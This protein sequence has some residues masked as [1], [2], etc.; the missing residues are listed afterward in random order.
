MYLRKLTISGFKSFADKVEVEFDQGVTGIIGPNGCGKS[1]VSDSIRWVL[2]EQNARRLRGT[3]MLDMIFN[4]TASRPAE[5][6]AEVSLLF[7]NSDGLLPVSY[8][9]VLITRRLFRNGESEYSINK[10][11]CRMK[12]VTDLFLDSGIGTSS[13]SLMEQGRVDMIVNAKP[14]ERRLILEE[15][16]GVSRFLHRKNDALRKLERTEGD[17]TRLNDILSELQRQR[18]S[19]ERQAR[20]ASLARKYRTDLMEVEYILHVRSGSK[21]Q[22]NLEEL[23]SKIKGLVAR[24]EA[25]EGEIKEVRERKRAL[26][27]NLEQQDDLNRKQRDTWASSNARLEQMENQLKSLTERLSEYNQLKVRLLQECEQD[28]QRCEEE[29]ERLLTTEQLIE[30][31]GTETEL[32]QKSIQTLTDEQTRISREFAE[33]ETESE[34][35]RKV[36]L[37]LEQEIT[38]FKNHQRLWDRDKEFYSSRLGKLNQEREQIRKELDTH[39]SRKEELQKEGEALDLLVVEMRRQL[40][41]VSQLVKEL[42]RTETETRSAYQQCERQWQQAH[43]RWESLTQLQANLAGFDE[44]VRFLLRGDQN[45]RMPQLLCTLAEKIQVEKG[46]EMA[47]DTALSRKLQ[48]IVAENDQVV[49]DAVRKLRDQKK[50]RV[51]FLPISGSIGGSDSVVVPEQ[52]RSLKAAGSVV[53]CDESLLP[54][55]SRMLENVYIAGTLEEALQLRSVLP[56]GCRIVTVEGDMVDSDGTVIGG[57]S[58]GSQILSRAAE[59]SQLEKTVKELDVQRSALEEQVQDLR[60]SISRKSSERDTLRQQLMER[61]NRQRVVRDEYER[62]AKRYERLEESNKTLDGECEDLATNLEKGA[63]E[64]LIR[65]GHLDELLEKRNI[66]QAEIETWNEQ[67][68]QAR[69]RRR[70]ISEKLSEEKMHLLEKQKDREHCVSN[71]QTIQRHLQELDRGITDKSRLAEQQDQRRSETEKEIETIRQTIDGNRSER[72]TIW[73]E[74]QQGEELTQGLRSEVRKIDQEESTLQ[75]QYEIL[76]KD[77]EKHDQERMKIQVENE[78][79]VKKLDETFVELENKEQFEKDSRPD[80]ELTEKLDFYRRRLSQLGVVNELAIEEFEEVRERC[81]FLEAQKK[82]LEKSKTNLL[83][84][85]KELHGTTVDLFLDTFNKVNE[86][87]NR[88]FRRMFNGGRAELILLEGDPMEAGIEIVVQPPG[89]KLQSITLLSGGEKALV[90]CALLFAIYEIKPCPFCFLDEID[91]PLDDNNIGR[92]TT[93][94][95]DYLDKSQFIIITHSKK[96]MEI[97]DAIYG[98]T[99][100]QEGVTTLYSM[101]FTKP[102]SKELENTSRRGKLVEANPVAEE[103]MELEAVGV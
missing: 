53:K 65:Q 63:E 96:T 18:R 7:D 8:R 90:A 26:N 56:S 59:I 37:N 24:I 23:N 61:E 68:E 54:F 32:L 44:G 28:K 42:Q 82:D 79:W 4:G 34:K 12:D 81:D 66:L 10:T 98:V 25:L 50:G 22:T 29:R 95:R 84:T 21:L 1:N 80:E 100:K 39:R 57:Y 13:Y 41:Q 83:A 15:A 60:E 78:Y 49:K 67:I 91:A 17:L 69:D 3:G 76:R 9:E 20:Q 5:G 35:R 36:F 71:I 89:K 72:D 2:G 38:E 48:A 46:F 16:A 99:M 64:A 33:V 31:L 70:V 92:F 86:N 27:Q 62:V 87:F 102:E 103:I 55:V 19:L 101:K 74:V 45:Q 14:T 93:M 52:I 47:I 94:L 73:K 43:S 97:C 85:A 11:K 77:R 30:S 51:A 40:D 58:A 88:S 75:D 6:M